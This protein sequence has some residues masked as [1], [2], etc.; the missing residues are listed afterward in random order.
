MKSFQKIMAITLSIAFLLL[1]CGCSD[2]VEYKNA[3]NPISEKL[4]NEATVVESGVVAENDKFSLVWDNENVC[5]QLINKLTGEKWSSTPCDPEGSYIK[6]VNNQFSP[7]DIE[8]VLYS[9]YKTVKSIGKD[10]VV[11]NGVVS[12]KRIEDGIQVIFIF[13]EHKIAIPV[14]FVLN[15]DGLQASVELK[16]IVEDLRDKKVFSITLLPYFCSTIN[17]K[18][19]YLFVPSGSGAIMC[20]DARGEGLP[21]SFEGKIY[22]EDPTQEITEK[23]TSEAN[24]CMPIYGAKSNNSTLSV[25]VTSGAEKSTIYANAGDALLGCSYINNSFKIRGYNGTMLEY[26][27]VTG[28]KLVEQYTREMDDNSILSVDFKPSVSA[29]KQGYTFIANKYREHLESKNILNKNVENSTL[30]L[31]ILG[32]IQLKK[33]FFG[34][35]Y[36]KVEPLTTFNDAKNII[37]NIKKHTENFDVQL[38]GFGDSGID[39]GEL[40]GGF[41]YNKELGKDKSVSELQKYCSD[42]SIKLYYDFDLIRFNK[43]GNGFSPSSDNSITSNEYPAKISKYSP[44]TGSVDEEGS[45]A[46]ILKRSRLSEAVGKSIESLKEM[47]FES[48]SLSS[49][50][51]IAYS[52]YNDGMK[53]SNCSFIANDVQEYFKTVKNGKVNIATSSA[54]DYVAILSDKIFDA[55]SNSTMSLSF[56]YDIPFYQ[57]VFKGY[58]DLSLDSVN[59]STNFRKQIL[60]SIETGSAL[61]FSLI[62]NYKTEYAFYN[63]EDLQFMVYKN[64]IDDIIKTLNECGAFLSS[65]KKAMIIEH[66][67]I[68]ENVR[69]TVFDN[70]VTV[71]V[72]YGES[73]YTDGEISVHSM[74]F[75]VR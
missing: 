75:K 71:Y 8:Y 67:L 62:E 1:N 26:G 50:S 4:A 20:T 16:N 53:Y 52:D 68:N 70:G 58:A 5:I 25:I 65:V 18:D 61:Q 11:N 10:A 49:L 54:N 33:H 29:E 7:I 40:G 14:N 46:A 39:I 13:S 60:K 19:N 30:S 22:G 35:P 38:V 55:P 32:G 47:G 24:I 66:S 9:G 12:A 59:T 17:S 51:N 63:H 21:R 44:V 37:S 27:G 2:T 56:D 48:I 31:K 23:Y 74:D 36:S 64:N 45:V 41:S 6:D 57:I 42:N 3:E 34:I 15:N 72:N 73:D 28:K 43:S 69:K